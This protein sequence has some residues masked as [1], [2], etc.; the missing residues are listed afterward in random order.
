MAERATPP[1]R[2]RGLDALRAPAIVGVVLGHWLV[3]AWEPGP[4]ISSPLAYLPHLAPVSWALQTLAVFFLVGGYVAG[5]GERVPYGSRMGAGLRRLLVPAA[6]LLGFWAAA[7]VLLAVLNGMP[8]ERL[9]AVLTP[10]LGPLWFLLV[11]AAF[12]AAAPW[13]ARI[14]HGPPVLM[15]IVGIV[16]IVAA[17]DVARFGLGAPSW[18]AWPNVVAAWLVPYLLGMAWARRGRPVR[19]VALLAGGVAGT[20]ALVG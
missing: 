20:A 13:L 15:G 16:G 9:R 11:F 1:D 12:T 14:R 5:H 4:V 8:V 7:G 19:P 17:L 6:A 2:D 3:T 10:V 18:I